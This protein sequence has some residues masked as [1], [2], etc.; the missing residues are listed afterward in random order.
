[1]I[2]VT[3]ITRP[4]Q[5]IST[6]IFSYVD[7]QGSLT[8][9]NH[10]KLLLPDMLSLLTSSN[11]ELLNRPAYGLS[12]TGGTLRHCVSRVQAQTEKRRSLLNADVFA[13]KMD[14]LNEIMPA[15]SVLDVADPAP[16]NARSCR[17]ALETLQEVGVRLHEET[18]LQ[19]FLQNCKCVGL[20]LYNLGM[21]AEVLLGLLGDPGFF[22]QNLGSVD[23]QDPSIKRWTMQHKDN[24]D[25]SREFLVASVLR[26]QDTDAKRKTKQS[27][28]DLLDLDSDPDAEVPPTQ[29]RPRRA[30][31][32]IVKEEPDVVIDTEDEGTEQRPSA[33]QLRL[34]QRRA[35]AED[36]GTG[37][38][39]SALQLRL[40]QR[41]AAAE[42]EASDDEPE[43]SAL[44]QRLQTRLGSSVAAPEPKRKAPRTQKQDPADIEKRLTAKVEDMMKMQ[45]QQMQQMMSL[46]NPSQSSGSQLNIAAEIA[47]G[48]NVSAE[49]VGKDDVPPSQKS[50]RSAPTELRA[51]DL[52]GNDDIRVPPSQKNKKATK[53]IDDAAGKVS[54]SQTEGSQRRSQREKKRDFTDE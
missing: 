50:K 43:P 40:Q 51:D 1:M 41:R 3:F 32:Q 42:P 14:F 47:A 10:E 16:Q 28:R 23:K 18:G 34:Q 12:E 31:R 45:M 19:A 25:R 4:M 7:A 35:V 22:R 24:I 26:R 48:V 21:Q 8:H 5:H 49:D 52:G 46:M 20:E 36:E 9:N 38:R 54:R 2:V 13:S 11:C 39:P 6:Q 15:L 37:Q 17:D 27:T 30:V 29:P 33:L 44:Q 53:E